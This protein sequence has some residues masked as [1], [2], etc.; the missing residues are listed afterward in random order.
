[1]AE[2]KME[3]LRQGRETMEALSQAEVAQADRPEDVWDEQRLQDALNTLKEMYIQVSAF[4]SSDS[5]FSLINPGS[6]T[7]Y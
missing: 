7:T 2:I 1:M 6:R 5:S 4:S 3:D